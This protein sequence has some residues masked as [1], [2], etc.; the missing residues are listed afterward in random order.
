M[1]VHETCQ[2]CGIPIVGYQ[3]LEL[4]AGEPELVFAVDG[5]CCRNCAAS[6]AFDSV[7]GLQKQENYPNGTRVTWRLV[8]WPQWRPIADGSYIL[9]VLS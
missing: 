1:S 3:R 8:R 2:R 4:S 5:A 9:R 6:L 7:A